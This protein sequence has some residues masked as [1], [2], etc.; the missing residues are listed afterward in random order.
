MSVVLWNTGL[1]GGL[2]RYKEYGIR[3]ASGGNL[4]EVFTENQL[5]KLF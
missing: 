3:L 5:L 4:K 1:L 2:R